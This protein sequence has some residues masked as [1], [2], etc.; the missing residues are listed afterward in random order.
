VAVIVNVNSRVPAYTA[1]SVAAVAVA[2]NKATFDIEGQAKTRAP[3]DTGHLRSSIAGRME[4][5]TTGVVEAGAHYAI[6]QEFGTYKMAA[7]PFM[8]PALEQV[9][10]SLQAALRAALL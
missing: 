10:P 4:A 2:V 9:K 3:V 5:A 7:Q 8:L 6:Y 1:K